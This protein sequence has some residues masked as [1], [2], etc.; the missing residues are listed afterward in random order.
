MWCVGSIPK[1]TTLELP[2]DYINEA[3]I[4]CVIKKVICRCPCLKKLNLRGTTGA[5][6]MK[7]LKAVL[8]QRG[9]EFFQKVCFVFQFSFLFLSFS[10]FLS[11]HP[12]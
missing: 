10:L 11:S 3:M 7:R 6:G 2:R 4:D 1:L 8:T 9:V 12:K 5:R